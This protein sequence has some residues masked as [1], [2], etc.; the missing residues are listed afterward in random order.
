[1]TVSHS[2]VK[3]IDAMLAK[4]RPIAAAMLEAGEADIAYKDG[5]FEVVGTDRR[6]SLF[7]VA[8]HAAALKKRG[9]IA[10]DLDTKTVTETPQTF[11]NGVQIAEVEIDPA[12]GHMQVARYAAVDDCGNALDDMIVAGQLHGAIA[13]G[14]GQALMERTVYDAELRPARHHAVHGL[15]HAAR[16]GHAGITRSDAVR[17]RHDESARCQ[18][19]RRSRNDRGDRGG[20][21]RGRRRH[22]DG[23]GAHRPV[24]ATAPRL[25]E[26]CQRVKG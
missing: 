26:A 8:S 21:E 12:T 23:A 15:R 11:P 13:S 2:V 16:R 24:P 20:D 6:V 10:E 1:M 22:P 9:E 19:R 25:W 4:G 17:A 7:A 18:G 14:L 3:A 5:N